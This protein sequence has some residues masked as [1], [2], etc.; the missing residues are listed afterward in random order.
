[1]SA[2][3]RNA[4]KSRIPQ[5]LRQEIRLLHSER[6]NWH[7]LLA[8]SVDWSVI[9]AAAWLTVGLSYHPLAYM[10]SIIVVGSRQRALRSLMH[11]ASHYKLFRDRRLNVWL[12]RLL[13]A[14]PLFSGLSGYTCA[15]CEHH[16]N[17][18]DQARDPKRRQYERLGLIRPRDPKY[19]RRRHLLRPLLLEHAPYNVAVDLL[20]RD[21]DRRETAARAVFIFGAVCGSAVLGWTTA[22]GLLWFVPY[23]TVYQVLRYWS[24]IADH[25]GLETDDVWQS[26]RSWTAPWLVRQLIA[27]HGANW[28]LSHHLYPIMPQHAIKNLNSILQRV[29]EFRAG[30]HC[31]GFLRP[32]RVD[33]PSVVQDIL[34]PEAMATYLCGE[35]CNDRRPG[36][37]SILVA[38]MRPSRVQ[39][40]RSPDMPPR[41]VDERID[42]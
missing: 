30:H 27:P 10:I 9:V 7:G 3:S 25:A 13:V 36:A 28:H 33:R 26:T 39:I 8:L 42:A 29:P 1:M 17:L 38:H 31:A 21:E 19:F 20:G 16:R 14:F 15:H 34:H 23:C 12:G 37:C 41:V 40:D 4:D 32:S 6:D 35:K 22:V 18:W 5:E 2:P 24:D 11:E